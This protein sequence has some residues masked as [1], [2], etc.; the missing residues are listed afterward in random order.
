MAVTRPIKY[1]TYKSNNRVKWT[2]AIVWIISVTIGSP[3]VLGLNTSPERTPE[4]CIF[5]N[6]DFIIY[7]SL[8]SFYIPCVLMVV[9]YYKIFKAIRERAKKKIGAGAEQRSAAATDDQHAAA[10]VLENVAQTRRFPQIPAISNSA[11]PISS[12]DAPVTEAAGADG[13][14]DEDGESDAVTCHVIRNER[15]G[16]CAPAAGRRVIG[17]SG[18]R[19]ADQSQ[20]IEVTVTS[21]ATNG[22]PDSGYAPSHI[23]ET[24]FCL[25]NPNIDVVEE[26][27]E[28]EEDEGRS[29]E[30]HIHTKQIRTDSS[31]VENSTSRAASACNLRTQQPSP[32][33]P[34]KQSKKLRFNLTRK[35][36]NREKTREKTSARLERK[37][38]KT[39]AIVLGKYSEQHARN[40]NPLPSFLHEVSL[41]ACQRKILPK[42][43]LT[44]CF[45][46]PRL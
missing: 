40:L 45:P 19:K 12:P 34:I 32:A 6:S 21:T 4:L 30:L 16:D 26:E 31:S 23:E 36:G 22:N 8:G 14:G 46:D 15:A 2:I 25:R 41:S 42:F 44:S 27:E 3:I 13:Q 28:D 7:S 33:V 43:L 29:R 17:S 18:N 1:A 11:I 38:T 35:A 9:L 10:V 37:A 24:Q 20:R 39:L 5:Y